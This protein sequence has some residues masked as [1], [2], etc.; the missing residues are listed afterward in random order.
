MGFTADTL[1]EYMGKRMY[2]I[3]KIIQEQGIVSAKEIVKELENYDIYIDVKT[4]YRMI[5]FLNGWMEKL[6]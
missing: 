2:Y 1:G 6:L 3:F 5:S 4:V